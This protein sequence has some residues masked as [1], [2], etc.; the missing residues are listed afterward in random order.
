MAKKNNRNNIEQLDQKS[1]QK[2]E[3]VKNLKTVSDEISPSEIEEKR[4]LIQKKIQAMKNELENPDIN[5]PY[6][7]NEILDLKEYIERLENVT[8]DE[9]KNQIIWEKE[10]QRKQEETHKQFVEDMKKERESWNSPKEGELLSYNQIHPVFTLTNK[11]T[12]RMISIQP[13]GKIE[14]NIKRLGRLK[15]LTEAKNT[16]EKIK[17][18]G[19]DIYSTQDR[20]VLFN[21]D[22]FYDFDD[23]AGAGHFNFQTE[24][25]EFN[26]DNRNLKS[27]DFKSY[28]KGGLKITKRMKAF[29]KIEDETA[30][31]E[32]ELN[33]SVFANKEESQ[34]IYFNDLSPKQKEEVING[35][36]SADDPNMLS[37]WEN[38]LRENLV[39]I[40]KDN[41][42]ISSI[43]I[44]KETSVSINPPTDEW[45]SEYLQKNKVNFNTEFWQDIFA[46]IE[47]TEFTNNLQHEEEDFFQGKD[48]EEDELASNWANDDFERTQRLNEIISEIKK[49]DFKLE[50]SV[51]NNLRKVVLTN[52]NGDEIFSEKETGNSIMPI[53]SRVAVWS[54][55]TESKRFKNLVD[56]YFNIIS[57]DRITGGD[58]V[59]KVFEKEENPSLEEI[60][61]QLEMMEVNIRNENG[62]ISGDDI[63]S[64]N[65]NARKYL[66]EIKS[67]T[68]TNL[69][70]DLGK[71]GFSI[72]TILEADNYHT[73]NDALGILGV[74]GKEYQQA[75]LERLEK[76]PSH[77]YLPFDVA[78]EFVNGQGYTMYD[79]KKTSIEQND[80]YIRSEEFI[81]KFGNWEKANRL[82]KLRNAEPIIKDGKSSSELTANELKNVKTL[83]PKSQYQVVLE[84]TQGDEGEH[85]KDIIK[86]ISSKAEAIKGK[87]EILT[88][89]K[90][91]PLAFKYTLGTSS[92]Y[93]SEWDGEDELFGY[94]ILNGDTQ[95]SEWGYTSLEELKN[96]T[97]KDKNGFPVMPEMIFYGLEDTIEKQIAVDYP[98]LSEKMGFAPKL[99]HNEE[100]ISEFGKEIF[101]TLQSRKLEQNAYNICCAAQFIIQ[102]MDSSEKKEIFSIMEKCGCKG[103]NGKSNTEDFLTEVV[104]AENNTTSSV[105]DRKRLYEKINKFC[106]LK[107]PKA[108]KVI[109]N[110]ESDYNREI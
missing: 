34:E 12:G 74:Y 43:D 63:V 17:A 110:T 24:E 64:S 90:K 83:L 82:E 39:Q 50:V 109:H 23:Y 33:E 44:E 65:D 9:I 60:V 21:E 38:L 53:A 27:W 31:K 96:I 42:F 36:R 108:N 25:F 102:T 98:E 67:R 48:Q 85:F 72:F 93:F 46:E 51:E 20:V 95:M 91:H 88:D 56:E 89:D 92:F 19:F 29:E 97:C 32:N 55:D 3:D 70:L 61:N 49:S 18:S 86:E 26:I 57:E 79:E 101:E 58:F 28:I 45:I 22:K 52:K 107:K 2:E 30:I 54:N 94:T 14:K 104:K 76:Y 81:S 68:A 41:P 15:N 37:E 10:N 78:K 8:D 35:Y 77:F 69:E 6:Y 7:K 62:W 5:Y 66:E 87:R 100:L 11:E 59:N 105:Y 16:I 80:D 75:V 13:T 47:M 99:N 1:E 106:S 4:L 73:F 103:K 84:Y 40:Q 71:E